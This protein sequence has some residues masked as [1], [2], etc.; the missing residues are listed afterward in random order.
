MENA[1]LKWIVTRSSCTSVKTNQWVCS[2]S[3]NKT[4]DCI[5]V[6]GYELVPCSL[7]PFLLEGLIILHVKEL[8]NAKS[9]RKC[10]SNK[11]M[12]YVV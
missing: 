7:H 9:K 11:A 4:K 12:R 3:F 2:L 10:L 1:R 8:G 5:D 6:N